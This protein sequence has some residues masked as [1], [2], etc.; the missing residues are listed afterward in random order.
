[1]NFKDFCEFFEV[2]WI[3][4]D[5][6]ACFCFVLDFDVS[7]LV[8]L[9]LSRLILIIYKHCFDFWVFLSFSMIFPRF[10]GT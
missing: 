3:F 7:F 6:M 1:M 4:F 5:L 8:F 9:V 2:L 10:F